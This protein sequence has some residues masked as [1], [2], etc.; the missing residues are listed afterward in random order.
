MSA[1]AREWGQGVGAQ[2]ALHTASIRVIRV[3][4]CFFSA[5]FLTTDCTD[6]AD[7]RDRESS[8]FDGKTCPHARRLGSIALPGRAA[9]G[10]DGAYGRIW[11]ATGLVF[12]L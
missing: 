9:E 11:L 2:A 4:R 5:W 12:A 1:N 7:R 10:R 6:F 3:I 8:R